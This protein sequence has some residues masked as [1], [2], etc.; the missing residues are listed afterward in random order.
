MLQPEAD[1]EELIP[2]LLIVPLLGFTSA[3]DRLGQGAG[4]YDRWLAAHPDCLAIGMAWD[5]QCVDA[6]PMEPTVEDPNVQQPA[7]GDS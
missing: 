2:E 6:V 3:C 1:A 5:C 4:H 7:S